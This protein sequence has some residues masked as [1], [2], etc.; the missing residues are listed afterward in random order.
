VK[1]P[2]VWL[3]LGLAS[4]A[5]SGPPPQPRRPDRRIHIASIAPMGPFA[6]ETRIKITVVYLVEDFQP[7]RDRVAF[8]LSTKMGPPIRVGAVP[9]LD[10][11]GQFWVE[12]SGADLLKDTAVARPLQIHF[13]LQRQDPGQAFLAIVDSRVALLEL[14]G[15]LLSSKDAQAQLLVDV[16]HDP[17]YAVSLPPALNRSGMRVWG[18]YRVCVDRAGQV[19]DVETW[20]NADR[21]VDAA[22][23]AKIRSWRYQP[24]LV[25]R[26]PVPFCHPIRIEVQS[27]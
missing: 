5:T 18:L 2:L 20:L 24:Y 6:A 8:L 16:A 12:F 22:W 27:Q 15:P 11:N 3:L 25:D 21:L 10:G 7:G 17:R 26:Q 23:M 4:C 9:L 1:A 19:S 13:A 14:P